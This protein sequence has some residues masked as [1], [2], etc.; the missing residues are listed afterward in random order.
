MR[1]LLRLMV[2]LVLSVGPALAALTPDEML[3]DA[4]LEARARALSV[5]VR[6]MVCQNQAIDDSDAPLARDLRLLIRERLVAGDSDQ[7]VLDFLV[8][9]YGEF[10][11]MRP[12]FGPHTLFLWAAP[13][14]FLGIGG[15]ALG[16]W[17]VRRRNPTAVKALDTEE[18]RALARILD[19]RR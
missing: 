5:E 10:V 7:D 1:H 12:T 17:L 11:L 9:R 19:E 15:L 4:E 14:L 3:D 2:V 6:C 16:L 13:A 8:A 18:E